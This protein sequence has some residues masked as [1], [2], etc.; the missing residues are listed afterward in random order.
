MLPVK[1]PSDGWFIHPH[2]VP[3]PPPQFPMQVMPASSSSPKRMKQMCSFECQCMDCNLI[4]S[5]EAENE[6]ARKS[7]EDVVRL[8]PSSCSNVVCACSNR[9]SSVATSHLGQYNAAGSPSQ[10]LVPMKN[11]IS[12]GP[13]IYSCSCCVDKRQLQWTSNAGHNY[14]K[15]PLF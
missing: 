1:P 7:S 4:P 15:R 3:G 13:T 14:V 10:L 12:H 11:M 6:S 2:M 5:Y 8:H 9:Y